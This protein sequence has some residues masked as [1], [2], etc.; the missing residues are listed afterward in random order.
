MRISTR[1]VKSRMRSRTSTALMV[2]RP[3]RRL[4][5]SGRVDRAARDGQVVVVGVAAGGDRVPAARPQ[6]GGNR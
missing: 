5:V 2:L 3:F 1:K 4:P 6:G